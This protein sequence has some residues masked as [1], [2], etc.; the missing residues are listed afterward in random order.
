MNVLLLDTNIY[1]EIPGLMTIKAK[2]N[3]T[4]S[5]QQ[6]QRNLWRKLGGEIKKDY[7]VLPS[8]HFRERWS[9]LGECEE[10][11][12]QVSVWSSP[13]VLCQTQELVTV[14]IYIRGSTLSSALW[15]ISWWN[16]ALWIPR[17]WPYLGS[18]AK[19]GAWG[20]IPERLLAL[21]DTI[22]LQQ[23]NANWRRV[24]VAYV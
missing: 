19:A 6:K 9:S 20:V 2:Q 14:P 16:E 10:L 24:S 4:K 21:D 22:C 7:S 13:S 18:T 15:D 12:L 3:K 23:H 8:S 5:K 17:I 11:S 1:W